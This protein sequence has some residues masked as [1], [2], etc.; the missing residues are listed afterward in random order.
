MYEVG[1][2]REAARF[3]KGLDRGTKERLKES[4]V[5]LRENPFEKGKDVKKLK[6][7]KGRQ[8]LYHLRVGGYRIIYAGEGETILVTDIFKREK[9][10]RGS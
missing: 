4:L 7:T 5:A 2:H 3:L 6:G 9:G 10:Y 1:V 8:D